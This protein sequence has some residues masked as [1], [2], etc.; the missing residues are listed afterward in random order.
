[1]FSP[2]IL[3]Q[4]S[5]QTVRQYA[6]EY[7]NGTGSHLPDGFMLGEKLRLSEHGDDSPSAVFSVSV[8]TFC[9]YLKPI[10]TGKKR[11]YGKMQNVLHV[12][13]PDC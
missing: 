10:G 9:S 1:M 6:G 3:N 7:D 2:R 11:K 13:R 12:S 8:L 5:A 4:S